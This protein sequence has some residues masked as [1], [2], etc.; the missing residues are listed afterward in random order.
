MQSINA[1]IG[2]FFRSGYMTPLSTDYN[3]IPL[4]V[5]G[6]ALRNGFTGN[7]YLGTLFPP[8]MR[9]QSESRLSWRHYTEPLF[10]GPRFPGPGFPGRRNLVLRY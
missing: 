7:R 4:A 3:F 6:P 5:S 2:Q 9:Y 10:P 1:F 8:G